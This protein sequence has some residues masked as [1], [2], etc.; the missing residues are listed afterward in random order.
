M[1]MDGEGAEEK[2]R[3]EFAGK[4]HRGFSSGKVG[5]ATTHGGG[6]V[7]LCRTV[8]DTLLKMSCPG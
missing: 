3:P 1:E 6:A 8:T 5:R 4:G 7:G 2:V